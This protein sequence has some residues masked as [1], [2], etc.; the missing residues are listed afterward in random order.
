MHFKN[1]Q[2]AH[3][4]MEQAWCGS[5]FDIP[6]VIATLEEMQAMVTVWAGI[7]SEKP[8]PKADW[9]QIQKC[10]ACTIEPQ[11]KSTTQCEI[12]NI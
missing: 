9:K 3:S 7:L 6:E 1:D 4:Q 11:L 2:A 5:L 8:A 12:L 10:S